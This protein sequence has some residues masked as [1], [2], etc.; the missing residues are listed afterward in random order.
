MRDRMIMQREIDRLT[1]LVEAYRELDKHDK[2]HTGQSWTD[3][4]RKYVAARAR[5]DELEGE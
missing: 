5:V 3:V 2:A 1:A 4:Y